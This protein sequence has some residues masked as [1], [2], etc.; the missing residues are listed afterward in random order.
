VQ[1]ARTAPPNALRTF[2]GGARALAAAAASG[3]FVLGHW[4]AR[5]PA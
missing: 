4:R 3:A 2:A 5:K 1:A